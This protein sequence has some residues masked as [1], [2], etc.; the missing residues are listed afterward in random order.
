MV[1]SGDVVGGPLAV[2]AIAAALVVV[3][4]LDVVGG[5]LAMLT[6]MT[7]L[8]VVVDAGAAGEDALHGA[9]VEADLGVAVQGDEVD[10]ALDGRRVGRA[11]L[12]DAPCAG[13]AADGPDEWAQV[14]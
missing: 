13:E 14:G 2:L 8:V 3:V 6:V 4:A 10:A 5:P 12:G 11:V 1:M 9:V 7:S